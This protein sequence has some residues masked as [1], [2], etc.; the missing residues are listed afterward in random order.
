MIKKGTKKYLLQALSILFISLLITPSFVNG[1]ERTPIFVQQKQIGMP[2]TVNYTSNTTDFRDKL[3]NISKVFGEGVYLGPHLPVVDTKL[4]FIGS[5][6]LIFN[7]SLT[8]DIFGFGASDYYIYLPILN[9]PTSFDMAITIRKSND[10]A[11]QTFTVVQDNYFESYGGVVTGPPY[12]QASSLHMIKYVPKWGY[13]IHPII[14]PLLTNSYYILKV[15]LHFKN[16]DP[17]EIFLSQENLPYISSYR[18]KLGYLFSNK[19][20]SQITLETQQELY[21]DSS[22]YIKPALSFVF[23]DGVTQFGVGAV[24]L[25]GNVGV[26]TNYSVSSGTPNGSYA[27]LDMPVHMQYP[28]Y[29]HLNYSY[30]SGG[31]INHRDYDAFVKNY[32]I[33]S[34]DGKVDVPAAG[35][36]DGPYHFLIYPKYPYMNYTVFIQSYKYTDN[37]VHLYDVKSNTVTR[38]SADWIIT[39]IRFTADR[40]VALNSSNWEISRAQFVHMAMDNALLINYYEWANTKG[41]LYSVFGMLGSWAE[42]Q[43]LIADGAKVTAQHYGITKLLFGLD[44]NAPNLFEI[45]KEVLMEFWNYIVQGF[46]ALIKWLNPVLQLA[47]Y[48]LIIIS[49]AISMKYLAQTL[50]RRRKTYAEI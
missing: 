26:W 43:R 31:N 25:P 10:G 7:I 17:L 46:N 49:L 44:V 15:S 8:S 12:S 37:I 18:V 14:F 38:T 47:V 39:K 20:V 3:T 28:S 50:R 32:I 1:E 33:H 45:L 21:D 30:K 2:D 16:Q 9:P 48:F 24:T 42:E 35:S 19:K 13:F 36:I 6:Q 34:T 40:Y 29:L 4:K 5:V 22:N 23:L 41:P 11:L 27:T